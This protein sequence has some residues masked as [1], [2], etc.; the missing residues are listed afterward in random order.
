MSNKNFRL[1]LF[2]LLIVTAAT[3]QTGQWTTFGHDP[4]RSGFAN[5]EHAFSP[6]NVSSLGLVWKTVVPN[7]PLVLNGLTAPLIVRG[8]KMAT[9]QKDLVIV[10]GSSDHI[11][12]MD[13]ETGD[14]VWKKDFSAIQPRPENPDWLCPYALN[15]TPGHRCC[16]RQSLRYKQ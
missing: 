5:D 10:A 7:E 2:L 13:A 4:Q 8:V 12:A 9:G 3:A 15:D 14:L 1:L 16:P 11:Y 6:S